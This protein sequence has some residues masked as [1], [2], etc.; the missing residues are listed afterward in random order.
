MI[1]SFLCLAQKSTFACVTPGRW[2]LSAIMCHTKD[3]QIPLKMFH[4]NLNT[5][6]WNVRPVGYRLL[7]D[8]LKRWLQLNVSPQYSSSRQDEQ[9]GKQPA[10]LQLIS[11]YLLEG[12]SAPY[13]D[14]C[15]DVERK[16]LNSKVSYIHQAHL[17]SLVSRNVGHNV[18]RLSQ[19]NCNNVGR[20]VWRVVLVSLLNWA[21]ICWPLRTSVTV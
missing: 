18:C 15:T 12:T 13:V 1:S 17:T 7:L 5:Q 11:V 20:H 21:N 9:G 2:L 4:Q 16:H 3:V 10:K 14:L 6:L 8:F 19:N